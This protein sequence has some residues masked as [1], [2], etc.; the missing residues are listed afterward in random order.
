M[1]TTEQPKEQVEKQDLTYD[2]FRKIIL[3]D[4]RI[5]NESRHASL[6]GR[7][8]V[9][10]GKAKFGIFGDGKEVAQIAMAKVFRNGD[11]RSGYYRDQ[12]FMIASGLLTVQEFFAQLYA[13]T[14]V[15][16][17]PSSAGRLMNGHYATRLLDEKGEWKNLTQL[18]NS[19]ADISPTAGQMPR[20]VGLAYASKLYRSNPDLHSEY[21]EKFSIKGNE[22]AFGTIGDA[23]TSEGLFWESVN[24]AGVLQIPMAVS[25]WDD[26]YGIS[27]PQKYQTTKQSISEALKGFEK[28][29]DKDGYIILTGKGWDYPG[30]CEMY[31]KGISACRNHH[32]PVLFHIQEMTQPQGHST[33][34]SHERYK[35]QERLEWEDHYDCIRKMREWILQSAIATPEELDSIESETKKSVNDSKKKAWDAF[36]NSIKSEIKNVKGLLENASRESKNSVFISKII[37]EMVEI[38]E[39]IRK[40][41]DSAVKKTL[42][43]LRNE[44]SSSKQQLLD[45]L[46]G[47]NVAN[48]DKFDSFLYSESASSAFK[49]KEEKPVYNESSQLVDGREIL[50]ANWDAQLSRQPALL[51]FGEDVG[52][53]GGVN[54]TYAGLQAKYGN[55]RIIDTGIRE[56]TIIGQ[57]IGLALRGLRP[58]AEIQYLDY[59]VY[60]LTTL[61]DDLACLHYRTKGG[62]KA[63]LIVSTRGHRLEGVWHS[64]SPMSM[65]LGSL[66]GM[67]VLTPR[68]MTLAAGFYNMILASDNPALVIEPL[69][70]YRSKEKMPE[71]PGAFR[72]PA[73]IPEILSEGSDVTIVTY[74]SCCRIAQEAIQQLHQVEISCELIDVQSL[75]PFDIHH[76]IVSSLK[77][78]NKIL[79]LDEDVPGGASAFMMQQVI[80]VQEGF[81]YL[82]IEPKTLS[83]KDHRPAYGSDGDHFSKP[84]VEDVF[85]VVYKLMHQYDPKKYPE[86][87]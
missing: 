26:G 13:H 75:I 77:K 42:R 31:E 76:S 5:V 52:F 3:E 21:F 82:D 65:I 69:N 49:V 16:A 84:S 74:G 58:V 70:G 27:V 35:S 48:K 33:S 56:A 55:N 9:L 59:L 30:L 80:E 24:A 17:D 19:S 83:A 45:W 41:V 66:R 44:S 2:D 43:L 22:V 8:E 51:I 68:N 86:F 12:T 63:P 62:Q 50:L 18:K 87:F 71:N 67:F 46:K 37:S 25:V 4:Y 28:T 79:F 32:I 36:N 1:S 15:N 81:R 57:G 14:D 7:K 85:D 53:I 47:W 40:D 39:P 60:A 11:F 54:Q 72:I 38:S 23:S 64:G 29:E 20:L 61:T 73:G 6:L 78:T 34:G 10:T